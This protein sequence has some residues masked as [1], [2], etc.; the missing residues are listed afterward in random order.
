MSKKPSHF[1]MDD[2]LRKNNKYLFSSLHFKSSLISD[3][4]ACRNILWWLYHMKY[5]FV[6]AKSNV[7]IIYIVIIYSLFLHYRRHWHHHCSNRWFKTHHYRQN[8]RLIFTRGHNV[9]TVFTS[10]PH[11]CGLRF[12]KGQISHTLLQNRRLKNRLFTSVRAHTWQ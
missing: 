12:G 11:T 1:K 3:I 10:V 4:T 5:S 8:L 9:F 2:S 6:Y 7:I